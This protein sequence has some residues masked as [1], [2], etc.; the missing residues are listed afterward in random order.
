LHRKLGKVAEPSLL[1][2]AIAVALLTPIWT[3]SIQLVG[4]KQADS[5]HVAAISS[6]E[7]LG[8]YE[9]QVVRVARNQSDA[10]FHQVLAPQRAASLN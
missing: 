7:L 6:R 1:F 4:L 2:S 3:A 5:E 8:T 10:E 9:A